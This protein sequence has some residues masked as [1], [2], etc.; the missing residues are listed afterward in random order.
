MIDQVF[1]AILVAEN[2]ALTARERLEEQKAATAFFCT[3]DPGG[4]AAT[5]YVV[6]HGTVVV[7]CAER[8]S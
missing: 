7:A 5:P 6:M 4:C 2:L 1:A 8:I 3:A